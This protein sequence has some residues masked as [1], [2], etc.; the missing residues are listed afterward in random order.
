[1][2]GGAFSDVP[3]AGCANI[4]PRWGTNKART[5]RATLAVT[6]TDP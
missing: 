4:S 6:T 5:R 2:G 1:M 3:G